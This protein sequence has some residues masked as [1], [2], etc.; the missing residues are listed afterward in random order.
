MLLVNETPKTVARYH[1]IGGVLDFAF[2]ADTDGAIED[3]LP[4]IAQAIEWGKN[5]WLNPPRFTVDGAQLLT[6]TSQELGQD[7]FLGSKVDSRTGDLLYNGQYRMKNGQT[8]VDPSHRQLG[9]LLRKG[10]TIVSG[11][12]VRADDGR[13]GQAFAYQPYPLR[14]D[15]ERVQKV[16]D[17]VRMLILPPGKQCCI[18]DW[19]G[20]QLRTLSNYF[21]GKHAYWGEYLF[22]VHVKEDRWL[23]VISGSA[24][25]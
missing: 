6:L 20:P 23:A 22:T 15:P 3:L 5:G 25:D 17:A 24:S 16:F 14:G 1:E 11:G 18:L 13:F 21:L 10:V 19:S 2:F 12:S 4:A 9:R 7:E 8:V